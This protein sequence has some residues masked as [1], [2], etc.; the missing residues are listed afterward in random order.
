MQCCGI[1]FAHLEHLLEHNEKEFYSQAMEYL[2]DNEDHLNFALSGVTGRLEQ[3]YSNESRKV[4]VKQTIVG[5]EG[6]VLSE[7]WI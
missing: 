5:V 7:E 1:L 2:V 3:L 6:D 4:P